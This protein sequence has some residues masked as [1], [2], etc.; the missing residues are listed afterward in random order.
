[1]ATLKTKLK[2]VAA[3]A[4][5]ELEARANALYEA[6]KEKSEKKAKEIKEILAK[7]SMV[8]YD[9]ADKKISEAEANM[10]IKSYRQAIYAKGRALENFAKWEA[11]KGFWAVVKIFIKSIVGFLA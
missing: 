5:D 9:L 11:Y 3:G 10:A 7:I 2:A 6:I 4:A 8:L 1:M